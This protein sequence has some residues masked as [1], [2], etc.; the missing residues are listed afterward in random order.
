MFYCSLEMGVA[1]IITKVFFS[2]VFHYSKV[3]LSVQEA[4][5]QVVLVYTFADA[6]FFN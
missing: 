2:P 3:A 6:C 4:D 5:M 1:Y